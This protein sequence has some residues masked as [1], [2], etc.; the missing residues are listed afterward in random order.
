MTTAVKC[1]PS[2]RF[3]ARHGC[4]RIEIVTIYE[5]HRG[6]ISVEDDSIRI[7]KKGLG[8]G[9]ANVIPLSA[10]IG[11][12]LHPVTMGGTGWLQV[13]TAENREVASSSMKAASHRYCVFFR[14][15]SQRD[16]FAALAEWLQHVG[17]VNGE[18]SPT[19]PSDTT[20]ELQD[21]A[22][23]ATAV[24]APDR[25]FWE[26]R[27]HQKA[28]QQYQEA[29]SDWNEVDE[30]LTQALLTREIPDGAPG[31]EA[32][33]FVLRPTERV[34][35][36]VNGAVLIEPR[37][38]PGTYKGGSHGVSFRVAKGVSYRV[39]QNRGTYQPGP[40]KPTPIDSGAALIGED[41]PNFVEFRWRPDDDQAAFTVS[42]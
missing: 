30:A 33:G 20:S 41:V 28:V 37:T 21:A 22:T 34:F 18:R 17:D 42:S 4:G 16:S 6:S 10:V 24:A 11:C 12:V 27:R 38:A 1:G 7:E 5:G 2:G 3:W 9:P 25:G 15:G 39:G 29:L 8:L 19:T 26:D 14:S 35:L 13:L 36:Q 23:A 31:P 40:T 32:D